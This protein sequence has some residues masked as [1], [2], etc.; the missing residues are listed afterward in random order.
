MNAD[1]AELIEIL[2]VVKIRD[3]VAERMLLEPVRARA[4][5]HAAAH[6]PGVGVPAAYAT[7]LFQQGA[8]PRPPEERRSAPPPDEWY[9][10]GRRLGVRRP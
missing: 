4:C 3:T 2:H 9:E 10:L 6:T 7:T 5:L 1:E 8:H